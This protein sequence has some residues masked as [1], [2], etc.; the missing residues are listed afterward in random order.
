MS[1]ISEI[2]HSCL[3]LHVQ[4]VQ[5][6]AVGID[7]MVYRVECNHEMYIFRCS[8]E[9]YAYTDTI[10]WLTA[11][12]PLHIPVPSVLCDGK[13]GKY[14]YLILDYIEGKDLGLVY[15]TLSESEKR[16]IAKQVISVQRRVADMNLFH[17]DPTWTWYSFL[18]EI[19]AR[20][21]ERIVRNGYFD[22]NKVEQVKS[23]IPFLSDYFTS[24]RPIPYLDDISTKNLLIHDGKFAGIVDIDWIGVGD[25]LTFIAL[26]YVALR[27]MDCDTDYVDY[28]LDEMGCGDSEKKAF[29]FYCLVYCVDFMGER[30]MHFGDKIVDVDDTII[31]RLNHIYD[32]LWEQWRIQEME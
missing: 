18:N 19:L 8:T 17:V 13:Y 4:C 26:T 30:G 3:N 29:L 25:S 20:A 7:N 2:F 10:R 31:Y 9:E 6:C 32:Q 27:N 5:R 14:Y 28:L 24:V 16:E 23:L 12:S 1:I 11:L 22:R 15:H 21:H